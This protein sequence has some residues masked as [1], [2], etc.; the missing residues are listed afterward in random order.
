M[1][2]LHPNMFIGRG[3]DDVVDR[4]TAGTGLR[5]EDPTG[6]HLGRAPARF[7]V[8]EGGSVDPGAGPNVAQRFA[9]WWKVATEAPEG[10][11]LVSESPD[12]VDPPGLLDTLLGYSELYGVDPEP[13]DKDAGWGDPVKEFNRFVPE[14]GFPAAE[15]PAYNPAEDDSD[16]GKE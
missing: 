1:W 9:N 10:N 3:Q 14:G 11:L 15:E 16:A 8:C 5:F 6:E 2:D 7:N 12:Y 13:A 4:F